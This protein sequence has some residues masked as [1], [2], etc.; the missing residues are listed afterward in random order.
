[1]ATVRVFVGLDY[2]DGGVQVCVLDPS[3]R[4]LANGPCANDAAALAEFVARHGDQVFAAVEACTG[5]ADLADELVGHFGWSVDL[6]HPG[7]VRRMKQ[8]PD[9]TDFSDA[10]VLAG[11]HRIRTRHTFKF[12]AVD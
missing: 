4:V 9:K 11:G 12:V 7:Y 8:T 2:H 3:G 6:A 1:M 10:R 5:S